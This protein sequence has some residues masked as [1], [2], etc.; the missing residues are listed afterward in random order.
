MECTRRGRELISSLREQAQSY[1]N[2]YGNLYCIPISREPTVHTAG[3]I[4]LCFVAV[5]I[6]TLIPIAILA[7]IQPLDA[8][9]LDTICPNR[10]SAFTIY[11]AAVLCL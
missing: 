1:V 6:Q 3:G 2:V 4:I 7:N 11:L 10:S 5:V 8:A 9:G